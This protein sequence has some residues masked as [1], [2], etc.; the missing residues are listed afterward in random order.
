MLEKVS[1][2]ELSKIAKSCIH[3]DTKYVECLFDITFNINRIILW[4]EKQCCPQEEDN[5]LQY[6]REIEIEMQKYKIIE[7]KVP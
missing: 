3:K 1:Q 6:Y 4:L 2:I 5:S 7:R